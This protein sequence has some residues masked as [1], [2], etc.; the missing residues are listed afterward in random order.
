[1]KNVQDALYDMKMKCTVKEASE[2]SRLK[3][4]IASGKKVFKKFSISIIY[5]L[6]SRI[7]L[8]RTILQ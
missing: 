2:L 7:S 5:V 4:Q 3:N 6:H 8:M 1:M